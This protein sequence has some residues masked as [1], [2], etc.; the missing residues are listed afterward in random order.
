MNFI[1]K[2]SLRLLGLRTDIYEYIYVCN[3]T[4]NVHTWRYVAA[5]FKLD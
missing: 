3:Y 5:Q 2:M 1:L 4:N